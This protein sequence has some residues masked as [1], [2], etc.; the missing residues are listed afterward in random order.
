MVYTSA[1]KVSIVKDLCNLLHNNCLENVVMKDLSSLWTFVNA[2][3]Q[4]VLLY[5][6]TMSTSNQNSM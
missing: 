6:N 5:V 1:L 4:C 2:F 3:N